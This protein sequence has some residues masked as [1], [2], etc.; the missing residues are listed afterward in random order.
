MTNRIACVTM[1][2]FVASGCVSG[3]G[4]SPASPSDPITVSSSYDGGGGDVSS[5]YMT[6]AQSKP[7][8]TPAM[9]DMDCAGTAPTFQQVTAFAKCVGCHASTKSGVDRHYAPAS[10][11]FDTRAA[12]EANAQSAVTMVRT[13][14]M[15]PAGSGL[16]LTDAEKRQLYDWAMCAD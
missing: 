11:N 1:F 2:A 12:A 4:G 6:P 16:T 10:V 14:Q 15:P 13:G 8:A 7:P 9:E 5:A 3:S